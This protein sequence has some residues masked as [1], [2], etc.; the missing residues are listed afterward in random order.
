MMKTATRIILIVIFGLLANLFFKIGDKERQSTARELFLRKQHAFQLDS[1]TSVYRDSLHRRELV[2]L[3]AF[4]DAIR[5]KE[6]AE[7][8]AFVWR[9]RYQK[10]KSINRK[11]ENKEVDSLINEIH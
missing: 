6:R 5:A 11:F 9:D 10:E 7:G 1:L 8:E 2:A 4:S 3:K